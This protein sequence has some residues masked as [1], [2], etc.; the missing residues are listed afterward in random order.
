MKIDKAAIFIA[1]SYLI[2]MGLRLAP[3]LDNIL[4]ISLFS[5][6]V[7]AFI[8]MILYY[9]VFEM[10]FIFLKLTSETH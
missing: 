9:F 3:A 4:I 10:K 1:L 7:S 2:V 8:W 6:F 5:P